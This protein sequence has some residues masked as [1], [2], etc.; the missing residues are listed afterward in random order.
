MRF[1]NK[2]KQLVQLGLLGLHNDF[3]VCEIHFAQPACINNAVC[4]QSCTA[5]VNKQI[6][7][8]YYEHAFQ[9][10]CNTKRYL[11]C[12]LVCG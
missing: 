2:H 4:E 3:Y 5:V 11:F 6:L 1:I 9:S 12:M 7:S 8:G 10:E